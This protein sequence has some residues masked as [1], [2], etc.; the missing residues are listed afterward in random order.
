MTTTPDNRT[1]EKRI[2]VVPQD[3]GLSEEDRAALREAGIVVIT[4]KKPGDV[5]LLTNE[6]PPFT[7]H[8][9]FRAALRGL[10]NSGLTQQAQAWNVLAK[11][12]LEEK[13]NG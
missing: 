8:D 9:M 13:P 1:T 6:A 10:A 12:V 5:R 11:L 7:P 3:C 4:V 2:L